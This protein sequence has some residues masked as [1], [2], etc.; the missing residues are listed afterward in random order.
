[1]KELVSLKQANE[2]K[3]KHFISELRITNEKLAKDINE[4]NVKTS[5]LEL[6]S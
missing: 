5:D 1:M 4:L 3:H 6:I 2:A